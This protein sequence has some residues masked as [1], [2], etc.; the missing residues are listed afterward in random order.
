MEQI[1]TRS[2][3]YVYGEIYLFDPKG[4]STILCQLMMY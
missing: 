2:K 3:V 1:A 4:T